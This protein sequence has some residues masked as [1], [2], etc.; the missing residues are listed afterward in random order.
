MSSDGKDPGSS[1]WQ[2][3][4]NSRS[5]QSFG[6]AQPGEQNE[7]PPLSA[8]QIEQEPDEFDTPPPVEQDYE[9]DME[10][11]AHPANMRFEKL[12][13]FGHYLTLI[14]APLL[15]GGLTSLF[16]LPL[17]ATG[18]ASI[19]PDGLW[20]IA[21]MIIAI[22]VAQ[23]L[24]VFFAGTNNGLWALA[25]VGGFFLFMLVGCF[26]I[27]GLLAGFILLIVLLI[28]AVL[29]ARLYVHPVPEG[30]IDIAFAFGK[31]SRTLYPGFNILLPWEKEIKQLNVEEI[32]WT[33]PVQKVQLSRTEDVILRATV[34]YQLTPE[35]AHLA[36]TQIKNWEE[37]LQEFFLSCIQ[38]LATTF[39]PE[40]FITWPDGVRTPPSITRVGNDITANRPRWEHINN[41]LFQQMRDKVALWGILIHWVT[42]RDVVLAPHTAAA[43]DVDPTAPTDPIKVK[44]AQ[45]VASS[46]PNQQPILQ[47]PR[48]QP[49]AAGAAPQ[50]PQQPIIVQQTAQATAP[51][52]LPDEQ[53]LTK[54]YKAVQDGTITDPDTIRSI[55]ANFQ[56]V[57]DDPKASQTV[58]F[59]AARAAQNLREQARQY[60]QEEMAELQPPRVQ[61]QP[62][63]QIRRTTDENRHY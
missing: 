46:A 15:F 6:Q 26:A 20:L 53:A 34:S 16:V 12:K 17:V 22:T 58:N 5:D 49:A 33:C 30:T 60:E 41:H 23:I 7:L 56:A 52:V 43:L 4:T 10:S 31:F 27:F 55:A 9:D 11:P 51:K 19:T 24:A 48:P 47:Q 14:L 28:V 18:R 50:K 45:F 13:Q 1:T 57:A 59:D 37:S 3:P 63:W 39:S 42:I 54:A 29:I 38:N 40:D 25:T 44:D 36:V 35:D 61:K 32:Q 21:F 8:R 2:G 62:P